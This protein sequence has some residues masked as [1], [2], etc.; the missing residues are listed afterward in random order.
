M[1]VDLDLLVELI[2]VIQ[3]YSRK[4][5]Q[6]LV[7]ALKN[8][9]TRARLIELGELLS[10]PRI[11]KA[12][13]SATQKRKRRHRF[14]SLPEIDSLD[15]AKLKILTGIH[16]GILDRRMFPSAKELREFA[17][18]FGL[19]LPPKYSRERI[20]SELVR[21]LANLPVNEIESRISEQQ[22]AR[23]DYGQEYENWVNFILGKKKTAKTEK[24]DERV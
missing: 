8:D 7:E 21:Y 5:W 23:R 6:N 11:R 16:E 22:F 4:D 10:A 18:S 20:A 14:P 15:K 1:S 12:D 13:S 19:K 17:F 3:R 9:S 24:R 2:R